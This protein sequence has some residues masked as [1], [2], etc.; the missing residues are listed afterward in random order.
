MH[1]HIKSTR[2]HGFTTVSTLNKMKCY[3]VYC[4]MKYL[5]NKGKKHI[6]DLLNEI[7]MY[8]YVGIKKIKL[9]IL[10]YTL[11][12]LLCL[13]F[14]LSGTS[15]QGLVAQLYF[16]LLCGSRITTVCWEVPLIIDHRNGGP[17]CYACDTSIMF[18]C[19]GRDM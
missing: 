5:V 1:Y 16:S 11:A 8:M 3:L 13:F 14:F 10:S 9:V 15:R 18:A 12:G 19:V 2:D 4:Q 6:Y 17:F 7:I